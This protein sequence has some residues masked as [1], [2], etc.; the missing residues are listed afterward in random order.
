MEDSNS[1]VTPL[2]VTLDSAI[3][4]TIIPAP[5]RVMYKCREYFRRPGT[6][7]AETP[8]KLTTPFVE[9]LSPVV[10]CWR[11]SE[12]AAIHPVNSLRIVAEYDVGCQFYAKL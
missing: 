6:Y 3:A 8:P 9:P 12:S 1:P 7:A 2:Q 5:E 4:A 10:I 11:Q